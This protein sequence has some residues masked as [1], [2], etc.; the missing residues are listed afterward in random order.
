MVAKFDPQAVI[1]VALV[2]SEPPASSTCEKI[3]RA[4][5]VTKKEVSHEVPEWRIVGT[6]LARKLQ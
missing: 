2:L 5:P 4:F 3:G 1:C 6:T